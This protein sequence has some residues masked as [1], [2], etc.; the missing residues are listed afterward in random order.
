MTFFRLLLAKILGI[1]RGTMEDELKVKERLDILNVGSITPVWVAAEGFFAFTSV[2]VKT[3]PLIA[4]PNLVFHP[5]RGIA[6][7]VFFN[8]ETGEARFFP[9]GMFLK[10]DA[11]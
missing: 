11:F 1:F 7:K 4:Q 3:Q 10:S 9:A 8:T 2:D 6:F 5:S